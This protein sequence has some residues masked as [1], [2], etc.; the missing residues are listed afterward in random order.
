MKPWELSKAQ[1]TEAREEASK[2]S[3][4]H[5]SP[6]EIDSRIVFAAQRRLMVHLYWHA[7]EQGHCWEIEKH[8]WEELMEEFGIE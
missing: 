6:D 1:I 8:K 4:H 2:P 3:P 7:M 5:P